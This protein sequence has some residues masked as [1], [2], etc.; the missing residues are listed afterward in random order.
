M[1][2]IINE[3]SE[4]FLQVKKDFLNGEAGFR[5]SD[6]GDFFENL[7][8]AVTSFREMVLPQE[9]DE[10]GD[11]PFNGSPQWKTPFK[12][13]H[14]EIYAFKLF[15][16]CLEEMNNSE[17]DLLSGEDPVDER[18]ELVSLWE[19]IE[20]QR[21]FLEQKKKKYVE[22][23]KSK[24][25]IGK[26]NERHNIEQLKERMGD[27]G[28]LE[29]KE[30]EV[31]WFIDCLKNDEEAMELIPEVLN[32]AE[33]LA[34]SV[35]MEMMVAPLKNEI[36]DFKEKVWEDIEVDVDDPGRIFKGQGL[37][38]FDYCMGKLRPGQG[39][40]SDVCFLYRMMK[41]VDDLIQGR[42]E[43]F[44]KWVEENYGVHLG[45]KIKLLKNLDN[46]DRRCFY[47][48]AKDRIILKKPA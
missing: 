37:K 12:I 21:S 18:I 3:C 15:V 11:I 41:E 20:K 39:L 8:F 28:Y 44:K 24:A 32:E 1:E 22:E 4:K 47:S 7:A 40:I 10:W 13:I 48:I 17:Y 36:K 43:E 38:L 45:D 46:R 31:R 25:V 34:N 23:E 30:L 26:L 2:G 14:Q 35:K 27:S 16:K 19:P 6:L 9:E 29:D 33:D 5:I 42:Q